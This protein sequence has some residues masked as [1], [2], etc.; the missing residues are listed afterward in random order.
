MAKI[1]MVE[2]RERMFGK[3]MIYHETLL[4]ANLGL[5]ACVRCLVFGFLDRSVGIFTFFA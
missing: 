2:S 4:R 5:V 3:T 1:K